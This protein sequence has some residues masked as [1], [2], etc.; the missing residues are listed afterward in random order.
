MHAFTPVD[1]IDASNFLRAVGEPDGSVIEHFIMPVTGFEYN[2]QAVTPNGF[3]SPHGPSYS[4]FLTLDAT[5]TGG[6][7]TD[8]TATLW[9]DPGSDDGSVSVSETT[10]PAFSNGMKHDIAL[11]TG[12]FV[13]ANFNFDP[14]TQTRSADFV[15]SMTP[16]LAGSLL[17]NGSIQPGTM[18]EEKLTTPADVFHTNGIT[19]PGMINWVTGSSAV[20]TLGPPSTILLPNV[21]PAAVHGGDRL[22]FLYGPQD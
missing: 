21:P 5:I 15:E 22:S 17:L 11:A 10:D 2:G 6:A 19:G 7:F 1:T 12:T 8:L 20:I 9:A 16:T 4:L 14:V 13:S 18:L 3:D